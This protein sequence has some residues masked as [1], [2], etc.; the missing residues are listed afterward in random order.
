MNLNNLKPNSKLTLVLIES[1]LLNKPIEKNLLS[2]GDFNPFLLVSSQYNF[3]KQLK[4]NLDS[5]IGKDLKYDSRSTGQLQNAIGIT[6]VLV[7]KNG[8]YNIKIGVDE[9]RSD[10]LSNTMLANILEYGKV[11]QP[12]K[13]FMK[14]TKSKSKKPALEKIK[15]T[16][17][18]EINKL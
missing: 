3:E 16:L 17:E 14:L 10:G 2:K 9:N 13:P 1:A 4:N 5:V 12:P 8:N 18:E 6:P 11:G 15:S 7:D